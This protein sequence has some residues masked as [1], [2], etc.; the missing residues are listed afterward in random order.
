M[1]V[2]G[3]TMIYNARKLLGREASSKKLNTLSIL[4]I[5]VEKRLMYFSWLLYAFEFKVC[6]IL[7]FNF[8]HCTQLFIIIINKATRLRNMQTCVLKNYYNAPDNTC[9]N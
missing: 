5:A 7:F 1:I 4:L 9:K 6:I 2:R 8:I 3:R